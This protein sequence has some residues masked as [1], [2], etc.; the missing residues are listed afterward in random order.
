MGI[1][2]HFTI[3]I[4]KMYYTNIFKKIYELINERGKIGKLSS[5]F[6]VVPKEQIKLNSDTGM[7]IKNQYTKT[8]RP[9]PTWNEDSCIIVCS[10]DPSL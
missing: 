6:C 7:P 1:L 9:M 10:N 8:F 2:Q 5:K 4:Y 3:K